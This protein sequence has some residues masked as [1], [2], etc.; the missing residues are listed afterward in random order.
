MSAAS[1]NPPA[2][3]A[4]DRYLS[5]RPGFLIRRLHQ[6]HLALFAEECAGF[7]VTPVQYSIMTVVRRQPGL[8]QARL[9]HEVGIDRATLANVVARLDS[10]DLVRRSSNDRDRRVKL[11][12]LT[13]AGATLLEAMDAPARRANDRTVE[14]LSPEERTLFLEALRRLVDCGN[15]YG[16]APLRME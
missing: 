7:D 2:P 4:F 10:R 16:R 5:Q 3:T 13:D 15:S 1:D 12:T 14:A 11:V 6:I 9:A 8:D